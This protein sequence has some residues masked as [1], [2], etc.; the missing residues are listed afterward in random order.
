MLNGKDPAAV[1]AAAKRQYQQHAA[2]G[3]SYSAPPQPQPSV[4]TLASNYV[5]QPFENTYMQQ[6]RRDSHREDAQNDGSN[7][8]HG[9]IGGLKAF[10]CT[11]CGKG[12]AR[13]SD[14]ARHGKQIS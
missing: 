4:P 13:R 2:Q 5:Q 3:V 14:L 9:S 1:A 11:T 8:R 6:P 12:F 10:G 7:S